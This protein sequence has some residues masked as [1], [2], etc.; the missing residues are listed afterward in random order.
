MDANWSKELEPF[1]YLLEV[2]STVWLLMEEAFVRHQLGSRSLAS[3]WFTKWRKL[4]V[5]VSTPPRVAQPELLGSFIEESSE[6][7]MLIRVLP[8]TLSDY[9]AQGLVYQSFQASFFHL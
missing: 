6:I 3:D 5:R 9:L 7:T 4:L 8:F 2:L 1:I